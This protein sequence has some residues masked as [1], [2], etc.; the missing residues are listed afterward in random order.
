MRFPFAIARAQASRNG[1][2]IVAVLWILG[3]LA[4]LA[5]IYS[6]Y[7]INTAVALTVHDEHLQGE[8][9]TSAGIEIA[10]YK[11]LAKP[12]EPPTRGTFSF[13]ANR[14]KATVEF[15]SEA[16]RIDLNAAPKE[17]LAGLF[18]TLGAGGEQAGVYAD[19][20]I[21]WR[22][23]LRP[24]TSDDEESI[25]R[26]AGLFYGPRHAPFP[27]T[28]ELTL[29]LGLPQI[30]VERALPLVTVYSGQPQINLFDAAPEVVASL[31]GM[32]PSILQDILARR[33]LN[34]QN[35]QDLIVALGPAG[36]MA[37]AKGSKATRV[38]VRI[39]FD[40]G[41]RLGSEAV[42]LLQNNGG[43]PYNVLSWRDLDDAPEDAS[44]GLSVR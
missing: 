4:T 1:F 36:G 41:R 42:I 21:T 37:T 35:P 44:T 5:T 19:R 9:I 8:A 7:V 22:T 33:Q 23:P 29:V 10:A 14:A 24:S 15:R 34:A 6:V 27:H 25:Y 13:R 2:I 11:L 38:T 31:P 26:A 12:N 39:N 28:G 16:A 40:N 3:A 17:L 43:E 20:I 32:T 30:L 18:R